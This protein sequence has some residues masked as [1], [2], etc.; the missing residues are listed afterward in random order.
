M[1]S[2]SSDEY[3]IAKANG[4]RYSLVAGIR[5]ADINRA[6]RFT[7]RLKAGTVWVNTF[8]PTDV[9]LPWGG[10]RDSGFGREHGDAALDNCTEPNAIW[11]NTV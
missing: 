6:H 2:F 11:I 4:T 5:S 9:R 10:N 1:I 8:G 7:K 3:A